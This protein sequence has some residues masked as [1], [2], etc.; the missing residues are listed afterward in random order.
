MSVDFPLVSSLAETAEKADRTMYE[1]E[2]ARAP[3]G[4]YVVPHIYDGPW[5]FVT[6]MSYDDDADFK[7]TAVLTA[8]PPIEVVIDQGGAPPGPC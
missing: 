2:A 3:G 7:A 6:L 4:E 1:A 5:S 8:F